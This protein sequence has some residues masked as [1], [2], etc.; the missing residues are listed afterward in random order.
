MNFH[1]DWFYK[2]YAGKLKERFWSFKIALNLFLQS[3]GKSIVETG[4]IRQ[5]DDWGAGMST[6][7]FGD[8]CQRFGCH[9][10]TVD[11]NSKALEVSK[12][13][14]SE[15]KDFI[16]YVEDDS[17]A[18]LR[19]FDQKIDLLYLDSMDCPLKP[20]DDALPAQ[21]HQLNEFKAAEDKLTLFSI[22]LLDDNQFKNG[23]KTKE[24]KKYL[25]KL[26]WTCV[27]DFHQS[28]WIP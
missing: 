17:V 15:Y 23:G 4:T 10:W 18:F 12:E 22:V 7:I 16:T 20:E 2:K 28:L 1:Q 25:R 6:L 8:F 27:M 24:L 9:L 14:T 26:G 13:V 11:N 19:E 5:R 3:G 21:I